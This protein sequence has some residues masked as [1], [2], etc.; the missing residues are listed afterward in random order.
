MSMRIMEADSVA[1]FLH[2]EHLLETYG[3][4]TLDACASLAGLHGQHAKSVE[5][6]LVSLPTTGLPLIK[7]GICVPI[8]CV[9]KCQPDMS[10]GASNTG[11]PSRVDFLCY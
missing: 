6:H 8:V 4:L 1:A 2:A 5:W 7:D 11:Q 10:S 3:K 9:Q